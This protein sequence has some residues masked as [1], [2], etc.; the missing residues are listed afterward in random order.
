[1]YADA[2]QKGEA[3]EE[4]H[5]IAFVALHVRSKS[6]VDVLYNPFSTVDFRPKLEENKFASWGYIPFKYICV[7]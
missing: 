5:Y 1:M 7:K 6:W 4:M 2:K 3:S